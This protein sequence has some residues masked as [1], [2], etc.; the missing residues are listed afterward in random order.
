MSRF[1]SDLKDHIGMWR[2]LNWSIRGCGFHI[3]NARLWV[4]DEMITERI[5]HS[6]GEE[7]Y[8]PVMI[9]ITLLISEARKAVSKAKVIYVFIIEEWLKRILEMIEKGEQE[10]DSVLFGPFFLVRDDKPQFERNHDRLSV[11][12]S[13]IITVMEDGQLKKSFDSTGEI[14]F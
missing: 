8:H 5:E 12:E 14:P 1:D 10:E 2:R 11:V 7:K 4:L 9:H 3:A 13:Q 6:Y